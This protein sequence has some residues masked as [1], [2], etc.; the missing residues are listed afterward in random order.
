MI[1]FIVYGE[2]KGKGRP[3]FTKNGRA[4]T[5][6]TTAE[7]ENAVKAAFIK[8]NRNFK[9]IDKHI[10]LRVEIIAYYG[11]PK[12]A[13]RVTRTQMLDHVIRPTKKPDTDNIAKIILDALNGIA[14]YDDAQVV[15]LRLKKCY[16]E[17]PCVC[18]GI[19]KKSEN[20]KKENE[21]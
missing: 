21:K 18:V 13:S 14:Y 12:S 9:P 11:I 19:D 5:P 3:R 17:I 15:E 1:T 10:P 4:Y 8:A 16:G 7:Y 20:V 6:V 2:P